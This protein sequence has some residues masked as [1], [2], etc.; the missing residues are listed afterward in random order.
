MAFDE[1]KENYIRLTYNLYKNVP[2]N[3]KY[4]LI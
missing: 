3:I 4:E 1:L 2:F